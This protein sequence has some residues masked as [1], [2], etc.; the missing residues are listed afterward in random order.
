MLAQLVKAVVVDVAL[1]QP[2]QCIF[3]AFGSPGQRRACGEHVRPKLCPRD[4]ACAIA[5]Y[6]C[7]FSRLPWGA[8]ARNLTLVIRKTTEETDGPHW[9][10]RIFGSPPSH[11][12]K[13][14]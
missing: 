9:L 7:G 8:P 11:R 13:P 12:R 4:R 14:D 1:Q 6:A 10:W 3:R 5:C 2:R